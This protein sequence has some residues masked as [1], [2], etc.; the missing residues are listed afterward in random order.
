MKQCP[1]VIALGYIHGGT[2]A[3][4]LNGVMPATTPSGWRIALQSTSGAMFSM[5]API[6]N[7]GSSQAS[8]II[9]TPRCT[10]ARDSAKVLP[11]PRE[12]RRATSSPFCCSRSRKRN[13]TRARSGAGV[14]RQAGKAAC[15]ACTARC[16]SSSTHNGVRAMSFPVDGSQASPNRP[17]RASSHCPPIKHL[18]EPVT[19]VRALSCLDHYQYGVTLRRTESRHSSSAL[20]DALLAFPQ[21][22]VLLIC[23]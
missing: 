11:C 18:Q 15:A 10:E 13:M 9:S 22:L 23:E 4:K 16:T 14:S 20:Y 8:S 17:V 2:M 12:T 19:G 1:H 21:H 7:D 6:S 3:G 5:L